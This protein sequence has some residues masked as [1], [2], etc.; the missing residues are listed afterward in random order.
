MYCY[1]CPRPERTKPT[2][3]VRDHRWKLYG[4]GRFFDVAADVDEQRPLDEVT[5]AEAAAKRKLQ[6]ALKS[7][8]AK[9]QTLLKF[10]A[11][12]D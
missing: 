4:D 11:A 9:G 2:R 12:A 8:A 5:G 7:M 10:S 6:A 1:Y 3:F